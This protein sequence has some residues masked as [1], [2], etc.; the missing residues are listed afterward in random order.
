MCKTGLPESE[1]QKWKEEVPHDVSCWFTHRSI[2]RTIFKT[3]TT[4]TTTPMTQQVNSSPL[5][6]LLMLTL[7]V[8]LS[9]IIVITYA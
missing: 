9:I 5:V 7:I 3:I 2:N 8:Y 6:L 4:T 1:E